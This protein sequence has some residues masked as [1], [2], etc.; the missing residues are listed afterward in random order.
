[1]LPENNYMIIFGSR[2]TRI[3]KKVAKKIIEELT[4]VF[5]QGY[6]KQTL[7]LIFPENLKNLS[8]NTESRFELVTIPAL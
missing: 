5:L 4:R 3:R 8:W 2:P 6:D 1:M 7:R